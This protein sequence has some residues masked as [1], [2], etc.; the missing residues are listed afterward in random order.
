MQPQDVSRASPRLSIRL[1]G[2]PAAHYLAIEGKG[3]LDGS[4]KAAEALLDVAEAIRLRHAGAG[5]NF[6]LEFPELLVW[7]GDGWEVLLR[8][9]EAVRPT[10]LDAVRKDFH[11][12]QRE[13]SRAVDLIRLEEGACLEG[14][15]EGASGPAISAALAQRAGELGMRIA[16]PRHEMRRAGGPLVVRH[17]LVMQNGMPPPERPGSRR[18]RRRPGAVPWKRRL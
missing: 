17:R 3:L 13:S 2:V 5:R 10:E 9:P 18:Q 6:A 8:V 14:T 7:E 11:A 16:E 15:L 12:R 1:V 4:G